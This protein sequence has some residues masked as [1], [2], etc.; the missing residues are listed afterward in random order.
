MKKVLGFIFLL[1][2]CTAIQKNMAI[3]IGSDLA[4][5]IY[6]SAGVSYP[7]GP[8]YISG[9]VWGGWAHNGKPDLG[10]Y[11]SVGYSTTIY[12]LRQLKGKARAHT[13]T[14]WRREKKSQTCQ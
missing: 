10:P 4:S 13:R 5:G 8:V 3:D 2:S 6:P 9:G 1:A 12:D 11:L 14:K 7:V